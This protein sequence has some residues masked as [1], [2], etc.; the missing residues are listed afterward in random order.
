MCHCS[1]HSCFILPHSTRH[2]VLLSNSYMLCIQL[3]TVF[4]STA[5]CTS[6]FLVSITA[7]IE[8]LVFF[9][10]TIP[11]FILIKKKKKHKCIADPRKLNFQHSIRGMLQSSFC[12]HVQLVLSIISPH[13]NLA[14][15]FYNT[16]VL[17]LYLQKLLL[18]SV[19][20]IPSTSL[21]V[22][23]AYVTL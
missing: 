12:W 22:W 2:Q 23:L 4:A 7:K 18:F 8:W 3:V 14:L 11:R 20:P 9:N 21:H 15:C 16:F 5:Y 1:N 13:L 17:C 10:K 6:S 19:V